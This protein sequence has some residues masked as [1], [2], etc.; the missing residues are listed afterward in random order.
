MSFKGSKSSSCLL[1]L[2]VYL[3][4]VPV[5]IEY[6]TV[7]IIP[8]TVEFFYV[9]LYIVIASALRVMSYI[10]MTTQFISYH[11]KHFL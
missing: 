11:H 1:N 4:K 10:V 9:L 8:L 3:S 2:Y 6:M 5:S 7:S